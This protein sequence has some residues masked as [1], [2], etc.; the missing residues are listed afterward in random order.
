MAGYSLVLK[1]AD[2]ERAYKEAAAHCEKLEDALKQYHNIL[3]GITHGA[4]SSGSLHEALCL[5]MNF[6]LTFSLL[7]FSYCSDEFHFQVNLSIVLYYNQLLLYRE[8]WG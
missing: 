5:F 1:D 2:Y 7:S 6:S 8:L 4:I 3:E